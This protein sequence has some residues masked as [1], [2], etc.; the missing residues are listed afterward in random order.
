MLVVL[1]AFSTV[2]KNGFVDWDDDI[3]I[4]ANPFLR[5]LDLLHLR[6]MLTS[7]LNSAWQP[8]GWLSWSLLYAAAGLKPW[9]YHAASLALHA[10]CAALVYGL[11]LELLEGA[12][13]PAAAAALLFAL[14]PLQ[15][16]S[17]AWA[18]CLADL[19]CCALVLGSLYARLRAKNALSY[20]LAAAAVLARWEAVALFPLV[21]VLD[22]VV[23]A[24]P[25]RWRG[26][27]PYLLAGMAAGAANAI[28]K[29]SVMHYRSVAQSPAAAALAAME[30]LVRV[31]VPA[32]LRPVY[33]VTSA[34]RPFGLGPAQALLFLA[35]LTGLLF[36]LRRRASAAWAAW[37]CWLAA[38]APVVS[39]SRPGPI[40]VHDRYAYLGLAAFA[41]AAGAA[42]RR[43]PRLIPLA[44]LLVPAMA[45][46]DAGR[47]AD[48]K[49]AESLWKSVVAVD[50][51]ESLAYYN[52]GNLYL[53]KGRYYEAIYYLR[54]QARRNPAKGLP[55]L[56]HAWN[57][58]GAAQADAGNWA[59]AEGCFQA[60]AAL[61]PR[62][63]QI[64]ANLEE[65]RRHLRRR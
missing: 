46:A 52:L 10:A 48:W 6:W 15:V 57:D 28:A 39:L 65:T 43:W 40:F 4:Y 21:L 8:L 18:S 49:S 33:L 5:G 13:V 12:A 2:L 9:A 19:L 7:T 62:E 54:E 17:V 55:N 34:S 22:H 45:W 60:A 38:F 25:L 11:G 20:A 23:L 30:L 58:L 63:P 56:A 16:E 1:A 59:K 47:L 35:A 32:A 37:L 24:K 14:H 64:R 36:V 27:L 51:Q 31:V 42:L 53:A 50:P 3:L 26:L 44:A 61:A 29:A 41:L